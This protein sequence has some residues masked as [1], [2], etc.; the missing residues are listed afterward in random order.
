MPINLCYFILLTIKV[1]QKVIKCRTKESVWKDGHFYY[2]FDQVKSGCSFFLKRP[3]Q[4]LTI[5][6]E[7]GASPVSRKASAHLGP[8]AAGRELGGVGGVRIFSQQRWIEPYY[9]M[10]G[11]GER[12]KSQ[13]TPSFLISWFYLHLATWEMGGG[14]RTPWV[15]VLTSVPTWA[16]APFA[17]GPN[18]CGQRV[19]Q[20]TSG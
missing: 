8:N 16:L 7:K 18:H 4:K 1:P 3:L 2:A 11:G 5:E 13:V 10:W 12:G 15:A 20:A 6:P 14:P 9:K 19:K 17:S